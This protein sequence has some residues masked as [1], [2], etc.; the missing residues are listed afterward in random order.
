MKMHL[1]DIQSAVVKKV[2]GRFLDLKQASPKRHLLVQLRSSKKLEEL[3]RWGILRSNDLNQSFLPSVLAFVQCADDQ[4]LFRAKRA[5]QVLARVAQDLFELNLDKSMFTVE[6][7]EEHA[8]KVYSGIQADVIE[9]GLYLA[10]EFGLL[11]GWPSGNP[12]QYSPNTS[13]LISD[14]VLEIEDLDHLWDR[15]VKDHENLVKSY[16]E[17]DS[18]LSSLEPDHPFPNV[19]GQ[20]TASIDHGISVLISHSSKDARLALALIEL[21]RLG[22]GLH[23]DQIRC[24]SVDGYRLPA[25]VNTEAQLRTEV[26]STPVLIGLITRDSLASPYVLFELGARWGQGDFMIPLLV[27]VRPDELRGPLTGLNALSCSN[28]AQLHQLVGDIG[29]RLGLA[30]Q[31]PASYSKY[32]ATL[33]GI[34]DATTADLISPALKEDRKDTATVEL[35]RAQLVIYP[36][37]HSTYIAAGT[38]I[39][40]EFNLA[41]EN[42]G[43]RTSNVNRFHIS[44]PK[45]QTEFSDLEPTYPKAVQGRRA[46]YA[47]PGPGF[48]EDGHITIP[49]ETMTGRGKLAFFVAF[50]P[51]TASTSNPQQLE[52]ID[53]V[54]TISDTA[55]ATASHEFRL[56]E[57]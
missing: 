36:S 2:L 41:I 10:P 7:I 32:V 19:L 1:T 9:L 33:K 43:S 50:A 46:V 26:T 34:A 4:T 40:A 38:R 3:I 42:K 55:G 49:S 21:L 39:Y 13:L 54:L 20:L 29:A 5:V 51:P 53:C 12:P 27:G 15:F 18:N 23:A 52:P 57:R 30:T 48:A 44:M 22:L 47:M 17:D 28:E 8:R 14:R 11:A 45:A 37:G 16:G 56:D 6:E 31:S 24:S 35:K 25:G